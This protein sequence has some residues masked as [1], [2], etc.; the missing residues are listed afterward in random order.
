MLAIAVGEEWRHSVFRWCSQMLS[1]FHVVLHHCGETRSFPVCTKPWHAMKGMEWNFCWACVRGCNHDTMYAT[2]WWLNPYF[3]QNAPVIASQ[4]D[5]IH[6]RGNSHYGELSFYHAWNLAMMSSQESLSYLVLSMLMLHRNMT[7]RKDSIYSTS[8]TLAT[9]NQHTLTDCHLPWILQSTQHQIIAVFIQFL[10]HTFRN[11][12][13]QHYFRIRLN[14]PLNNRS[15]LF[16]IL[17]SL[18]S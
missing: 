1:L 8:S 9:F 16:S 2:W 3:L 17:F 12:S 5:A 6:S 15:C 13:A 10:S 4:E 11:L 7:A 14:W 18:S